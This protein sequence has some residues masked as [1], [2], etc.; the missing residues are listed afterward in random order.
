MAKDKLKV[1]GDKKPPLNEEQKRAIGALAGQSARQHIIDACERAGLTI[2]ATAKAVAEGLNANVVRAQLNPKGTKWVVSEPFTDHVTR[3][4][5]VEQATVLLDL[6]PVTKAKLD[7][8]SAMSDE[9][10]DQSLNR[11]LGDKK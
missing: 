2:E 10:I 3:L 4:K 11:L 9:E 5:A 8:A 6:K 1:G 7:V